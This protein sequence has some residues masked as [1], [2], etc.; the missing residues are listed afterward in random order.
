MK[1]LHRF[2]TANVALLTM[3]AFAAPLA[4]AVELVRN[5]Q[6]VA[7]VVIPAQASDVESYAAKE[8]QYHVESSTGAR[9]RVQRR[10]YKNVLHHL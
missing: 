2:M 9:W 4:A 5:G 7:F 10:S 6:P 1:V 8:L 3:A